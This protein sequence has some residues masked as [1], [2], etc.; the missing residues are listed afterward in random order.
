MTPEE[1]NLR[2]N[3]L[4][5]PSWAGLFEHERAVEVARTDNLSGGRFNNVGRRA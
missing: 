1:R 4:E 5:S 3:A 2:E